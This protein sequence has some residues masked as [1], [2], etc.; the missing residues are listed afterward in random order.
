MD[1]N[2]FSRIYDQSGSSTALAYKVLREL[3]LSTY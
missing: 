1:V 3:L 2:E